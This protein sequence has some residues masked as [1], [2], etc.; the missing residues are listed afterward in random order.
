[1]HLA[2]SDTL[3]EEHTHA[4]LASGL[5]IPYISVVSI[6]ARIF[7][8][9]AIPN[10]DDDVA[11]AVA[12]IVADVK[13]RSSILLFLTTTTEGTTKAVVVTDVV[14]NA[15]GTTNSTTTSQ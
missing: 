6:A 3:N 12:I 9:F 4:N 13:T 2:S 11:V 15:D 14:V 7:L 10:L 8:E 1:M 5:V